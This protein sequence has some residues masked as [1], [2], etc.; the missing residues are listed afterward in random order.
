MQSVEVIGRSLLVLGI[1][2][3]IAIVIDRRSFLITAIGYIVALSTTV[4]DSEGTGISILA[5]GVVLVVLGAFWA[6]IRAAL[7]SLLS[8]VLP[9]HRLPP[10]H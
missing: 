9:L 8:G 6:R 10:S 1:F 3:L 5:L 2:A 4:F 7:L